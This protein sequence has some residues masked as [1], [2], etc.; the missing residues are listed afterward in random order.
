MREIARAIA[1][2]RDVIE[3]GTFRSGRIGGSAGSITC[4]KG[5]FFDDRGFAWS[6]GGNR[7]PLGDQE[8]VGGDAQRGVMMKTPPT[9]PLV[10]AKAEFLLEVLVIAFDAPAQFGGVRQS[11]RLMLVGKVDSQFGFARRPFDQAPLLRP[12]R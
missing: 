6:R 7:F 4:G 8:S 10:M 9:S 11:L 5:M 2:R 1:M 3:F 12:W